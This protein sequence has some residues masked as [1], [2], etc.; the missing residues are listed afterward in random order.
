MT[1]KGHWNLSPPP[2]HLNYQFNSSE[3]DPFG[4]LG[5]KPISLYRDGS[6]SSTS[7]L[8]PYKNKTKQNKPLQLVV[9]STRPDRRIKFLQNISNSNTLQCAN[10][11]CTKCRVG[12]G[13]PL[14]FGQNALPKLD[15]TLNCLHSNRGPFITYIDRK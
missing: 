7:L 12:T 9:P 10:F 8:E 6:P 3:E 1:R 2:F 15:L 5:Q 13:C 11:I 4:S 14:I